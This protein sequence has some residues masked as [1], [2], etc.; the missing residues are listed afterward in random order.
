VR[1][2]GEAL[3]RGLALLAEDTVNFLKALEE[4]G[5]SGIFY[6]IQH[7]SKDVLTDAEYEEFGRKYD[8]E[9]LEAAKSYWFNLLHLHGDNIRFEPFTD[10]PVQAVNWHDRETEPDLAGGKQK[11]AGAVCGGLRQT[12]TMMLGTAEDVRAEARDAIQATNGERFILGTGCV[13][14]VTSP[15]GNVRAAREIVEE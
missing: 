3:H 14:M 1:E 13:T 11:F 4:T 8:L 15:Y 10:Y 2:D 5:I 6:A 12:E 7:A 9:V